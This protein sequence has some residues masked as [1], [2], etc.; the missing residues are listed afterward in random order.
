MVE[1]STGFSAKQRKDLV[2]GLTRAL[3]DTYALYAK[4]H[5]YH[6]NVTGPTFGQL[7]DLFNQQYTEMWNALDELAERIR[8]L[9]EYAPQGYG[10]IANLTGIKDGDPAKDAD[11]MV[12]E[13][14]RDHET[15]V[16]TLRKALGPAE[17]ADDQ[18]TID[19][20]TQRLTVHEKAAWML[21]ATLG[22]K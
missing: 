16:A 8:A 9:G 13:L 19:L 18:V 5:G 1:I 22:S 3:G 12:E 14:M 11:G 20:I 21:R 15:V 7:H 2:E 17:E 4:T 6:W 10:A